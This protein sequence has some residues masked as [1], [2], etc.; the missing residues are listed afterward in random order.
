VLAIISTHHV[1]GGTVDFFDD[2][3]RCYERHMPGT[4]RGLRLP[5]EDEL[6]GDEELENADLFTRVHRSSYGVD[7]TYSTE[8]YRRLLTTYSGHRALAEDALNGLLACIGRLID[9]RYAG[10]ITKRYLF[11]LTVGERRRRGSGD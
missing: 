8:A 5:S 11:R 6:P 4:E 9:V 3:Q 2:V 1:A 10:R 7:E